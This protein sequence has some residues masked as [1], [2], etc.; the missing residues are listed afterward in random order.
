MYRKKIR[1]EKKNLKRGKNRSSTKVEADER[2]AAAAIPAPFSR[3]FERLRARFIG[4]FLW[5]IHADLTFGIPNFSVSE[6]KKKC[7]SLI[8]YIL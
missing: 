1:E 6:K 7:T 5:T 4:S 2:T 8:L 3:D